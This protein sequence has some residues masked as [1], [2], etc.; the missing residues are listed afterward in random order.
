MGFFAETTTITDAFWYQSRTLTA[1][2]IIPFWIV[3][4]GVGATDECIWEEGAKPVISYSAGMSKTPRNGRS[5]Y[6][7]FELVGLIKGAWFSSLFVEE[8]SLF[9]VHQ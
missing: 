8:R 1:T 2:Q 9:W 6:V 5:A 7:S 4:T 3:V